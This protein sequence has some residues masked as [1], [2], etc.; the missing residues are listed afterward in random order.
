[1]DD[2]G[3]DANLADNLANLADEIAGADT[4]EIDLGNIDENGLGDES[5]MQGLLKR[6]WNEVQGSEAYPDL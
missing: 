1:M 3:V 6:D 5:A 2:D 4:E